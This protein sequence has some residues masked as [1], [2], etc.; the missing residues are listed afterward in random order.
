MAS[1]SSYL[2]LNF[3]QLWFISVT[4]ETIKFAM[5]ENKNTQVI[6]LTYTSP[7]VSK[8]IQNKIELS[9]SNLAPTG[10]YHFE[11]KE[12]DKTLFTFI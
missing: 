10:D 5:I 7:K 1:F 6:W 11:I 2:F 4:H 3:C 12:L 9:H 8:S